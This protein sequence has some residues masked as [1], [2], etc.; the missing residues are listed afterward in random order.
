MGTEMTAFIEYDSISDAGWNAP[1]FSESSGDPYS[2][3]VEGGIYTGSKDYKFFG[4]IAGVRNE[5][6]IPALFPP[7]GLPMNLSPELRRAVG[8]ENKL[9]DHNDSWLTLGEINAALDHQGVDRDLLGFATHT[10]I[11][12]MQNLVARLGDDRVRLVFGFDG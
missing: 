12:I 3:T 11:A 2:L 1:P 7:R 4:A 6:G 8:S 9:G 10:I 5:T